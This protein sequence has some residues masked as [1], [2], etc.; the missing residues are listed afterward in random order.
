MKLPSPLPRLRLPSLV[1]AV[2]AAACG[3]DPA[4]PVD[5][6]RD[7][8]VRAAADVSPAAVPEAAAAVLSG[9]AQAVAAAS[10]LVPP[11]APLAPFV[12][13]RLYAI[14]NIA[15]HDA[16]NAIQPRYER[17]A[18]T[19]AA[20]PGASPAAAVLSA[21]HDAIIAAAPGAQAATDQW[22]ATAIAPLIGRSGVIE[23]ISIGSQAAAAI[24][25]RRAT[26]GTAGGGVA[27]YTPG[28]AIGDYQFTFP[29]N[30]P[31]FDFFG[32][33]GFADGSVWGATVTPFAVSSTTQF[34]APP[35]Y[36]A[37]SN[38]AAVLTTQYT[39]D[40]LEVQALGCTTCPARTAEQGEIAL[41]WVE[42]SPAA[43]NR[44]ARTV[45][46]QRRLNAW[47]IARLF[48]L[49]QMA[50][51]DVYATTMESKYHYDFWRPVTA[52]ERAATDNN[53]ATAPSA[54]WEV[55]AFPTPPI[56]EYPSAH[57]SAG[58]C[59]AAVLNAI[60]PGPTTFTATSQSLPGVTRSF[61]SVTAAARENA[62]SRIYVG[63]HFR[64]AVEVGL[65]QGT[66]VGRHV[67][68]TTL[69]PGSGR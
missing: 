10:F 29:F 47:D 26:D 53:P 16:L 3:T 4:A 67:A 13:A 8:G 60:A 63:Y 14:A 39:R 12:E 48:A 35:P 20:A 31:T 34:R 11:G 23:G 50:Q 30:T 24:I 44:I 64:H 61:S 46:T 36:G 25:A 33:G 68:T 55:V 45:A 7:D 32:T 56:P 27:P 42:S 6:S 15:M 5:R 1:F 9:N 22:Y 66:A 52:V 62:L 21:A 18:L 69:R 2:F 51:F 57:A 58:G 37:S 38:P 41:F 19:S 28:A 49:L 43:W 54:G 17:Y 65:Q 40:F 59:A